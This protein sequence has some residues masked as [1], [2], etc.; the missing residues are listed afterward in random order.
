MA[1]GP[2]A[3]QLARIRAFVELKTAALCKLPAISS[4]ITP[5]APSAREKQS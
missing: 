3:A 4:K 5:S 2:A 1:H